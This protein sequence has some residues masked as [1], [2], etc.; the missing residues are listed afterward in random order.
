METLFQW[1]KI[2]DV[3]SNKLVLTQKIKGIIAL[4]KKR[5]RN[6]GLTLLVLHFSIRMTITMVKK[7]MMK[8][9][10]SESH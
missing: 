9:E 6:I 2:K 5:K 8:I 4:I 10:K 1:E 3:S 7:G